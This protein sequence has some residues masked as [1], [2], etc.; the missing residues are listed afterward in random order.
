MYTHKHTHTETERERQ[1]ERDRDRE[2]QRDRETERDR[3]IDRDREF[4]Y[5]YHILFI[6]SHTDEYLLAIMYNIES[7]STQ[8]YLCSIKSLFLFESLVF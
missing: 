2:R 5:V 1:R 7:Y 8:R 6:N 4:I 3:D